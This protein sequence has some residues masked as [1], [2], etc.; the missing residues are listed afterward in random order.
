MKIVP[1]DALGSLTGKTNFIAGRVKSL[2]ASS[3]WAQLRAVGSQSRAYFQHFR[4]EALGP[5]PIK[6]MVDGSGVVPGAVS[7]V[8]Q[9]KC[10]FEND[11]EIARIAG[12][13]VGV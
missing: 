5:A 4:N 3:H 6:V 11:H 7:A 10:V 9:I 8:S 12:R 1:M 13:S 2:L